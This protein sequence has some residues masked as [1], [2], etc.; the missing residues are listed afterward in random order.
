MMRKDELRTLAQETLEPVRSTIS[1]QLISGDFD[2]DIEEKAVE[3]FQ[4][5]VQ[6]GEI[7]VYTEERKQPLSFGEGYEE[8]GC[9][10]PVDQTEKSENLN[11]S[12]SVISFWGG[13]V[14]DRFETPGT[15]GAL[16]APR[17]AFISRIEDG[18]TV[19]A[20]HD[21]GDWDVEISGQPYGMGPEFEFGEE[22]L[23]RIAD[24]RDTLVDSTSYK[25]AANYTTK[26]RNDLH[27]D[28]NEPLKQE[29]F[30]VDSNGGA[31]YQANVGLGRNHIGFEAKPTKPVEAAG[32][33]IA[34]ALNMERTDMKGR[35]IQEIAVI[36]D[37]DGLRRT[38]NEVVYNPEVVEEPLR[39]VDTESLQD[40][41]GYP[42]Q[43]EVY[44]QAKSL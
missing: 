1:E 31:I 4:G 34:E 6:T 33:I 38:F 40:K 24:I 44:R 22:A 10:D 21:S 8:A 25:L 14:Q 9:L 19:L 3:S 7:S 13:E 28:V 35:D 32:G 2:Q 37:E 11:L 36:L 17:Y 39:L 43:E 16:V 29:G 5:A 27:Q 26:P 41:F 12:N 20:Y 18:M 23:P 15:E 30:R 42:S